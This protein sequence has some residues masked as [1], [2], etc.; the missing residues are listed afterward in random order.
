MDNESA[1]GGRRMCVVCQTEIG[2]RRAV[3]VVEDRIIRIIRAVKKSLGIAQMNQLYVCEA[4]TL[5]HSERRR[6]FEKTLLF[7]SVLAGTMLLLLLFVPILSGRLD[8]WAFVSGVL[9]SA[10]ILLVP[11]MFRYVPAVEGAV[12][13]YKPNPAAASPQQ[14]LAP[15]RMRQSAGPVQAVQP[16]AAEPPAAARKK[17]RK[18]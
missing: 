15:A 17:T 13:W 4:C 3:P 6:S 9:V 16:A 12:P 18:K 14:A 11:I 2:G 5:K 8:A 1:Q 7:A 10:I